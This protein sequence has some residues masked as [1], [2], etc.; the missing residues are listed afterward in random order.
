MEPGTAGDLIIS[1]LD[2][3][4]GTLRKL[5]ELLI[6]GLL[7]EHQQVLVHEVSVTHR[8][9]EVSVAHSSLDEHGAL[10]CRNPAVPEL[11]LP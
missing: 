3:S 6:L 1:S 5:P 11:V 2:P 9:S 4:S 8:R 10:P 7:H